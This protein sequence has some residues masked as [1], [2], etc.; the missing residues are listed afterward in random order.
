MKFLFA[1]VQPRGV[2]VVDSSKMTVG[3]PKRL[4]VAAHGHP[5]AIFSRAVAPCL[6]I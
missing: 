1:K 3:F 4:Q 2:G 5:V 6:L